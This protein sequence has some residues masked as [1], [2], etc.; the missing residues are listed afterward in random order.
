MVFFQR[1]PVSI[2]IFNGRKSTQSILRII[3][4]EEFWVVLLLPKQVL[5]DYN[6]LLLIQERFSWQ[7]FLLAEILTQIFRDPV[8]SHSDEKISTETQQIH[9]LAS[10]LN[11][12]YFT[13]FRLTYFFLR[14]AAQVFLY[15]LGT[16]F[17][18]G[19]AFIFCFS[20]MI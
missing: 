14:L 8:L 16:E 2:S 19:T 9:Q 4:I 11:G 5:S 10:K 6:Y 13:Y 18:F 20:Y 7:L 17:T 3:I 12:K 1:K 15:F